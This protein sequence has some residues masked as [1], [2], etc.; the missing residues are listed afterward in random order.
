PAA[1]KISAINDEL[2][3]KLFLYISKRN[4]LFPIVFVILALSG[5][6]LYLRYT[7]PIY[8]TSAILQMDAQSQ[9][10]RILPTANI[11]EDDMAKQIELMR[12]SVFLKRAL[13]KLPL[14]ITYYSK[15]RVL[16]F[17]L[18]RNSPFIA[19]VQVKN[20]ALYGVPVYV[21]FVSEDKVVLSY[22]LKG[23]MLKRDV[24]INGVSNLPEMDVR[25]EIQ[26]YNIIRE[27][28]SLFSR[29]SYFFVIN[30]PET[31]SSAYSRDIRINVLN[32]AAKTIQITYQGNNPQKA[33]DIVNTI[34]EE[35]SIYDLEKKAESAN[36]ILEFIDQ[37]LDLLFDKLSDSE[38]ELE[39]FKKEHGIDEV[40][41]TP[42][43]T[44]QGRVAEMENQI[45]ELQM[46]YSIFNEIEKS[47][48]NDEQVD[49]FRLIAILA[50]S[51]FSGV[52][53]RMLQTLQDLLVEREQLLYQVTPE[54]SQIQSLNH[55]INIQKR[56]VMES[57]STLREQLDSR[58][59]DLTSRIN[60]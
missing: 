23:E 14:E 17:E 56:M 6:W 7:P 51:E 52:V 8:Q 29:N 24:H 57:I 10:T 25:F 27:Q 5:A 37:Q 35:F 3:I 2:D 39:S 26:N 22:N 1:K 33:A 55:Q 58:I 28:Q 16:N 45:V 31:L 15:G 32:A 30:N 60:S 43:P 12:S 40:A 42:L 38:I 44:L 18:Y 46:E 4:I 34:A 53:S 36:N 11:Y 19:Q 9:A 48:R 50:G 41:L 20:P 13:S 47:L 49:I 54:S 59:E 21:D